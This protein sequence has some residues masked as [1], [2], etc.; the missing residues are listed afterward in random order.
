MPLLRQ[1]A[2]LG[3]PCSRARAGPGTCPPRTPSGRW[4]RTCWPRCA[5]PTAWGSPRPRSTSRRA[6]SS[7]PRGPTPAIPTPRR[8]SPRWS[9]NP[10]IVGRSDEIVK[11]WEGCLSIPGIRGHVPRHRRIRA[12]YRTLDGARGRARVRRLRRPGLPARGRPPPRDRLPRPARRARGTSSPRRSSAS[13]RPAE[14]GP[15][16]SE[17]HGRAV[18]ARPPRAPPGPS[19]RPVNRYS[20]SRARIYRGALAGERVV[21]EEPQDRGRPFEE[22]PL[23]RQEPGLRPAVARQGG[24][25]HLPVEPGQVRRREPRRAVDVAGLPAERVGLPGL[26]VF[27]P[28]DG[29]LGPLRRHHGEQAVGV[30][31][32]ER[33]DPPPER[34]QGPGKTTSSPDRSRPSIAVTVTM[35]APAA[36]RDARAPAS[37]EVGQAARRP[38]GPS[39]DPRPGSGRAR[40]P[41]G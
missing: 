29:D 6:C 36:A 25:P 7:S 22:P 3:H 34:L 21:S 37:G 41:A 15:R 24:E 12:R 18:R 23:E 17:A 2:Q 19:P 20:Y 11:G 13:S 27:A 28:L 4:S 33:L 32:P 30:H 10:E 14:A 8:W 38:S 5:T 1:I 9:C 26:A 35:T 31:A 40:P 39:R 16:T